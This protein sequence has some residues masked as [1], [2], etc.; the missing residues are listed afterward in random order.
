MTMKIG[1]ADDASDLAKQIG[2]LAS[3]RTMIMLGPVELVH[4][5]FRIRAVFPVAHDGIS[6]ALVNCGPFRPTTRQVRGIRKALGQTF[7][8]VCTFASERDLAEAVREVWPCP[9]ADEM[10][11]ALGD[12]SDL[13]PVIMPFSRTEH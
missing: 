2:R 8:H 3:S 1:S 12:Q 11:A 6:A 10:H 7:H 4:G 9:R 5:H 13:P